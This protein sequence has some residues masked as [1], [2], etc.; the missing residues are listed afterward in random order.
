MEAEK[1]VTVKNDEVISHIQ[2]EKEDSKRKI[3]EAYAEQ[4]R[5]T[6]GY[7]V[8][9]RPVE[10][11]MGGFSP[12]DI[13]EEKRFEDYDMCAQLAVDKFNSLFK[14]LTVTAQPSCML[15]FYITFEAKDLADE[16]KVKT[17]QTEVL[18]GIPLG[19]WKVKVMRPKPSLDEQDAC[20]GKVKMAADHDSEAWDFLLGLIQVSYEGY[21]SPFGSR[22]LHEHLV[23]VIVGW[24]KLVQDHDSEA[25]DFLL[26]LSAT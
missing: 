12:M 15:T 25:W 2:R 26:G 3:F 9:S 22:N 10:S 5:K 1:S 19:T 16:A 20:W 7:E 11:V 6:E 23:V 24:D 21:N 4:V 18:M 13:S 14:V 17:Y 8:T